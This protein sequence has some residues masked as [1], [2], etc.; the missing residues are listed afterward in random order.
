MIDKLIKGEIYTTFYDNEN[1][2]KHIFKYISGRL[3]GCE[4]ICIHEKSFTTTTRYFFGKYIN[5]I[6]LSNYQEI[7][8]L[9]KCIRLNRY[10]EYDYK[11][12]LNYEIWY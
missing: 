6:R 12:R 7:R 1:T 3:E 5:N 10:V 4:N 2:N 9:E 11:C 8:H